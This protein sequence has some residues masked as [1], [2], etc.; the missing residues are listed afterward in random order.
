MSGGI[1]AQ[2]LAVD[3]FQ[4][5]ILGSCISGRFEICVSCQGQRLALILG[6]ATSYPQARPLRKQ[7]ER[8]LPQVG[9]DLLS[10]MSAVI[11]TSRSYP[12]HCGEQPLDNCA[13]L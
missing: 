4:A 3:Y 9:S 7:F 12:Q 1:R 2:S 6:P 10:G 8:S 5:L 11:A 13:K